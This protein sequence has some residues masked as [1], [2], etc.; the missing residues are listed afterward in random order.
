MA[1][2]CPTGILIDLSEDDQEETAFSH[3]EFQTPCTVSN[4]ETRNG[5]G[6]ISSGILLAPITPSVK[7][8]KYRWSPIE[9]FEDHPLQSADV[10]ISPTFVPYPNFEKH[11]NKSNEVVRRQAADGP[12]DECD[13]KLLEDEVFDFNDS[14]SS[15]SSTLSDDGTLS[16]FSNDQSSTGSATSYL[17]SVNDFQKNL[18]IQEIVEVFKEAT[19][20]AVH[21]QNY[22]RDLT[23]ENAATPFMKGVLQSRLPMDTEVPALELDY[24]SDLENRPPPKAAL[25]H[26]LI[27]N[28][29]VSKSPV[30]RKTTASESSNDCTASAISKALRSN[31][32]KVMVKS[33]TLGSKGPMK[34]RI[35]A[36]SN[37]VNRSNQA[38]QSNTANTTAYLPRTTLF[39][40]PSTADRTSQFRNPSTGGLHGAPKKSIS[41]PH[42]PALPVRGPQ[43]ATASSSSSTITY[44]LPA[45]TPKRGLPSFEPKTTRPIARRSIEVMC[46]T[47][48]NP[49]TTKPTFSCGIPNRRRSAGSSYSMTPMKTTPHPTP[50]PTVKRSNSSGSQLKK[51]LDSTLFARHKT[52]PRPQLK[53]FKS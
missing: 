48:L 4:D 31:R 30:R 35:L 38:S 45:V 53:L 24:L 51:P 2:D 50:T 41:T 43:S 5:L 26:N 42:T 37:G 32:K 25:D 46:T 52:L 22:G 49:A 15:K 3:C 18:S 11:F 47:P 19:T 14:A 8:M 1:T 20:V 33:P 28:G 23:S 6:A 29:V 39:A 27:G 13:C 17:N 16:E 10:R 40:K 44:G 7:K 34:A 36:P 9:G 12:L 21:L